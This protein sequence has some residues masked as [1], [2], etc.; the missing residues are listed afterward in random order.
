MASWA[1]VSFGS[2]RFTKSVLENLTRKA[3]LECKIPKTR[4]IKNCNIVHHQ[5]ETEIHKVNDP[6]NHDYIPTMSCL[7]RWQSELQNTL[8]T[9]VKFYCGNSLAGEQCR[10]DLETILITQKLHKAREIM[11]VKQGLEKELT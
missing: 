8:V 7:L 10:Y 4:T 9:K 2:R 1:S 3:G 6:C 11:Q 5:N